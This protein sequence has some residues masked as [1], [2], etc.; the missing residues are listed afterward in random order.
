MKPRHYYSRYQHFLKLDLN[1]IE[2][3]RII[4][5]WLG[6]K[7][8]IVDLGCGLGYFTHYCQAIGLDKDQEAIK[9]A[10]KIFPTTKFLLADLIQ[11]MPFK[12]KEV[13]AFLCYNVLEHLSEADRKKVFKEIKRSLKPDGILIAAYL[14]ETFWFNRL[15]ALFIPDYGLKDPTHLVAWTPQQF[16]EEIEKDFKIIKTKRTSQYGKFIPLTR[17]LKGEIILA[18]K[19]Y[20]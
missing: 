15:L 18:A 9:K 4:K 17:F 20:D 7:K 11:K 16:Q 10:E 19:L 1:R 13:E 3:F 8:K 14:D 6:K 2:S 12:D 5:N